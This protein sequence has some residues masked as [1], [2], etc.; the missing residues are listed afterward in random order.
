MKKFYILSFFCLGLYF[1]TA[2]ITEVADINPSGDSSPKT[3]FIKSDGVLYFEADNGTIGEELYKLESGTVSLIK[4]INQDPNSSTGDSSPSRFIEFNNKLYFRAFDG[5]ESNG[6]NATELWESD[7]TAL[8]TQLVGDL[9]PGASGSPDHFFVFNNEL[10]FTINDGPSTQIWQLNN[11]SPIKVTNDRG[12]SFAGHSFPHITPSFVYMR[13]DNNDGGELNTFD[14]ST[15]TLVKEIKPGANASG[16]GF[17]PSSDLENIELLGNLLFFEGDDGINGDEVWVSDG[18][19]MGTFLLANTNPGNA[20]GDPDYFEVYNGE[21]FFASEDATGYQ[22]WKSDGTTMGTTLVADVNASGNDQITNLFSDGTNLY[23]SATNGTN[24]VE[25]WTYNTTDGA[26]MLKDINTTGNS[27]PEG[28]VAANGFVFFIADDGSGNKLWVTDGTEA[29]TVTVASQYASSED[30]IDVDNLTL[31]NALYFS[32]TGSNGNELF[33]L[34]PFAFTLSNDEFEL[35][36]TAIIV[37]PNPSKNTIK[38]SGLKNQNTTYTISDLNGRVVSQG[39]L[40]DNSIQH[41]LVS[42]LYLLNLKQE[43]LA[44]ITKKIIV[45]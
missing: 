9:N 15:T 26:V 33:T 27:N 45:E 10:F 42:G 16:R 23:F 39:E 40:I 17:L 3:F 20:N 14:G 29:G 5:S 35:N 44:Q 8:G 32:G 1:C 36:Q 30:P 25:L 43:G 7:G 38:I 31:G 12:G 2:Q 22:L 19:E 21:M 41:N 11:G 18:T 6:F 13:V 37:F 34:D 28:F 24:G 4:D